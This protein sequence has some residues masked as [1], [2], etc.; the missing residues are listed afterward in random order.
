MRTAWI[1]CHTGI[2]YE[3][4]N[5]RRDPGNTQLSYAR[6]RSAATSSGARRAPYR[7]RSANGQLVPAIVWLEGGVSRWDEPTEW[8]IG[9]TDVL[10]S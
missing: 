5:E 1:L 10:V 8:P 9:C 7:K 2:L 3:H 4:Q 6:S